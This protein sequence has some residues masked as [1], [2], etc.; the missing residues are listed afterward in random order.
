MLHTQ[1]PI[2]VILEIRRILAGLV[3]FM[4]VFDLILTFVIIGIIYLHR[5]H[6]RKVA[7][8]EKLKVTFKP[9]GP[10]LYKIYCVFFFVYLMIF[11]IGT[12]LTLAGLLPIQ[13][14]P[15]AEEALTSVVLIFMLV[16]IV[17]VWPT[18]MVVGFMVDIRD[19]RKALATARGSK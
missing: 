9:R 17:G 2:E 4:L 19:Q 1:I 18:L 13:L 3:L 12:V 11:V 14:S 15:S 7:A 10:A 5:R 8:E 6:I 16:L